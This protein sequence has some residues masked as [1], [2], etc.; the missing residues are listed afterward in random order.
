MSKVIQFPSDSTRRPSL[1][2]VKSTY[3]VREI[4]E[5]FGL[6]ETYIRRWT[7]EGFIE[8][9]RAETGELRY[10]FRALKQFRR[11]RELRAQGLSPKQIDAELR[12]QLNLFPGPEG[13]L[14]RL[15]I[16]QPR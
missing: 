6:S 3:T 15:P 13:R 11:V 2:R 7:R 4:S 16:R 14:I 12:G 8:A 5:Q 10:D 1:Q 9:A